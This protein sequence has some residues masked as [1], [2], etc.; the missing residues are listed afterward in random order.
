[1]ATIGKCNIN[2]LMLSRES[3]KAVDDIKFILEQSN[4]ALLVMGTIPLLDLFLDKG[5]TAGKLISIAA[6]DWVEF[7][8]VLMKTN[9]ITRNRIRLVAEPMTWRKSGREGDFWR[10]VSDATNK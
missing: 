3:L 8:N 10:C 7:G 5:K 1:M 6:Y 2:N 9:A 4:Y